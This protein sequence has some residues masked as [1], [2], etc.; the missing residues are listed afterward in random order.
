MSKQRQT[1]WCPPRGI[2]LVKFPNR[3]NQ[4]LGVQ[5]RVDGKRKTKTFAT[6]EKQIDFAKSLAGDAHRNGT[7]AFRLDDSEAREWRAFRAMIGEKVNLTEVVACWER[8]KTTA[9]AALSWATAVADYTAA[10]EAEGVSEKSVKHYKPI[11]DRFAEIIGTKNVAAVTNADVEA[12]VAAQNGSESETKKTR[13]ARVRALF[14]WLVEKRKLERS[15][16]VGLKA[17]KIVA[18]EVEPLSLVQSQ[19]LFAKNSKNEDGRPIDQERRELCGRLAL[20]A[21]AGLR[22]ETAAQIVAT[23]IRPDGLR[24]PAAKIKT[25]KNQ[26]LEGLPANLNPWLEWSRPKEWGMTQRQYLQ[27]KSAAFVRADV[28]HPRNVLRKSFASYHVAA[29]KNAPATSLILCHKSPKLLHDTYRGIASQPDGLAYFSI[30][31]P[32][33]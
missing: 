18:D 14:N 1:K 26:F 16:F 31:P 25:K 19:T 28:P 6:V 21:F 29:F 11:F 22:F 3:P 23:E 9:P 2:T 12:F 32:S 8:Y 27:A 15:P 33:S 20:E 7:A 30:V 24:I 5:W 10:K 4:P 13:F 17:P